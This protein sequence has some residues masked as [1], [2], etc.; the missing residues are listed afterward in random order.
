MS[1]QGHTRLSQAD[2]T[3]VCI[4]PKRRHRLTF[5]ADL[6]RGPTRRIRERPHFGRVVSAGGLWGGGD[7]FVA[8]SRTLT[9][10]AVL[11]GGGFRVRFLKLR[12]PSVP[13]P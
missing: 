8:T 12:R 7:P 3:L 10:T 1:V 9:R 13:E 2:P 6:P 4:T 5:R 11:C